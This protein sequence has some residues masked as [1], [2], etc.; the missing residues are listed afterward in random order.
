MQVGGPRQRSGHEL[1]RGRPDR[2]MQA[3]AARLVPK[4]PSP[5]QG[6]VGGAATAMSIGQRVPMRWER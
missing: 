6:S 1:Y 5:V 4:V 2:V 3:M